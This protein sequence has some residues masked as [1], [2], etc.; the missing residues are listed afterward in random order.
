MH[1]NLLR[2]MFM[3]LVIANVCAAEDGPLADRAN[4]AKQFEGVWSGSW[5]GGESNGTVFQPVLAEMLIRGDKIELSGFRAADRLWGLVKIDP[6]TKTIKVTS[7]RTGASPSK[8]IEYKYEATPK[9]LTLT[10]SDNVSILLQKRQLDLNPLADVRLELVAADGINDEGHLQITEYSA[11]KFG[12]TDATFYEPMIR[13]FKTSEASIF[14]CEENGLKKITI[15]E[16]RKQ[17]QPASPV[18]I[19]YRSDL[20]SASKESREFQTRLGSPQPDS[21]AAL[22]MLGRTLRVGT[23]V[24]VFPARL[25]IPEP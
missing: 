2:L 21:D 8:V 20:D 7:A 19:A 24:F 9:S 6:A 16:A 15:D 17:H 10:D 13:A 11:L 23:L 3:V 18:A 25:A 22:K 5:G 14:L 4:V 1:A 12:R